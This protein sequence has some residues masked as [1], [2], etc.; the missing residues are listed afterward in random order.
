MPRKF[1]SS[2]KEME[3]FL[4]EETIGWLGLSRN[5]RSYVVPLNYAYV[6]GKI[7]FHCA[8]KGRKLDF[9][10][11]NRDVCFAVGRQ[12]GEVRRH[13]GNKVCHV[14]NDSVL[15]FGR[16]RVLKDLSERAVALNAFQHAFRPRAG[17]LPEKAVKDCAA[18]EIVIREMTGRRER[19]RK[20]TL[21][22][23][24]F[25]ART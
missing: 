23:H 19:A 16:A 11:A 20:R 1:V 25:G 3:K 5:G 22:R 6:D 12:T 13:A 4:R 9:I 17:D 14:D 18:I 15:C 24:V 2:R 7:Y 8:M 10:R 21:W